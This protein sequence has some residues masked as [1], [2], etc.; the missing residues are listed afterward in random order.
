[1]NNTVNHRR[2]VLHVMAGGK[3]RA[4]HVTPSVKWLLRQCN[5]LHQAHTC[6]G[7]RPF[8]SRASKGAPL[9]SRTLSASRPPHVAAN[10]SERGIKCVSMDHL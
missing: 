9:V 6:S 7:V 8:A 5:P 10:K 3:V 1:M 4:Q 2:C